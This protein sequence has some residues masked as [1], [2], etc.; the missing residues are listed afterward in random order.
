LQRGRRIEGSAKHGAFETSTFR[1]YLH[2]SIRMCGRDFR[3]RRRRRSDSVRAFQQDV[4]EADDGRDES[5]RVTSRRDHNR[6]GRV[7]EPDAGQLVEHES[8]FGS[9]E[10]QADDVAC[11]S[12]G[13]PFVWQSKLQRASI[14]GWLRLR[15]AR[16]RA[17]DRLHDDVAG[18]RD[19]RRGQ[20][21]AR[22]CV[23]KGVS[24]A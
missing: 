12:L 3:M 2:G 17:D 22:D 1:R 5:K 16:S 7:T 11:K 19:A 14:A 10:I 20:S 24:T 18:R 15:H 13:V 9:F 6:R 23:G 4:R 8:G 21:G